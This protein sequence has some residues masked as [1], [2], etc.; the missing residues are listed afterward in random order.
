MSLCVKGND[1]NV[2]LNIEPWS[3]SRKN[4]NTLNVTHVSLKLETDVRDENIKSRLKTSGWTSEYRLR[5]E[6]S[7]VLKQSTLNEHNGTFHFFQIELLQE[8]PTRL[9][10]DGTSV[11]KLHCVF[12]FPR[13]S[14]GGGGGGITSRSMEWRVAMETSGCFGSWAEKP[15]TK[16]GP[17][18]QKC[19]NSV[20]EEKKQKRDIMTVIR[21]SSGREASNSPH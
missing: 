21:F 6:L 11:S 7:V 5:G 19:N 16:Q 4:I 2:S 14:K 13:S 10:D 12:L 9:W 8:W 3:N 20:I 18:S 17:F 1:N 15:I